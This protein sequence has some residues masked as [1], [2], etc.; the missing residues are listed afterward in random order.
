M[1][2]RT[3]SPRCRYGER[4]QRDSV[5]RYICKNTTCWLATAHDVTTGVPQYK[6][7][8]ENTSSA[9][10]SSL[11]GLFEACRVNLVRVQFSNSTMASTSKAFRKCVDPC[12][13]YLTPDDTHDCCVFCLGM[14]H[15]RDVLEGGCSYADTEGMRENG[16]E[17]MP[18]VQ[19]MITSLS[20]CGETSSLKAP[21]WPSKPLN[22]A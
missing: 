15:A 21:S 7:R 13:R 1:G 19:E 3:A 6:C 14:E 10:S 8:R 2:T 20:L 12:P 17:G 22:L 4:P 5:W 11:T 18:P 9:F 16:Y